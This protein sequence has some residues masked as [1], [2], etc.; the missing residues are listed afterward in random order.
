M[1][2]IE[3][4]EIIIET[5]NGTPLACRV[6]I[7]HVKGRVDMYILH[8]GGM[9]PEHHFFGGDNSDLITV[10]EAEQYLYRVLS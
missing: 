6:E 1:N 2:E 4:S 5:Y 7:D 3:E 8:E 10:H 9:R